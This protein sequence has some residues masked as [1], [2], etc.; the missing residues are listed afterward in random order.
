MS[1]YVRRVREVGVASSRWRPGAA[2]TIDSPVALGILG[3][4]AWRSRGSGIP[5]GQQQCAGCSWAMAWLVNSVRSPFGDGQLRVV[6]N[7]SR[8]AWLT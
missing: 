5:S 4:K 2:L 7:G 6:A 3:G 8:P 1:R